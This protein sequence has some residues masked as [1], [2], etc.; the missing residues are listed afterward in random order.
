M[1]SDSKIIEILCNLDDFIKEFE[2]ILTK[3]SIPNLSE[4]KKR[5][6]TY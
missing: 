1:I 4:T 5:W 6:T 2:S 3:N